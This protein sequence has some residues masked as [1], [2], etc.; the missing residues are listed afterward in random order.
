MVVKIVFQPKI[1]KMAKETVITRRLIWGKHNCVGDF[2][3]FRNG[4]LSLA[5]KIAQ[6]NKMHA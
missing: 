2:P 5:D 3:A 1:E 6:G 4:E